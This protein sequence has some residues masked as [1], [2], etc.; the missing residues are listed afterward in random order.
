MIRAGYG[1]GEI[2]TLFRKRAQRQNDSGALAE[3]YWLSYADTVEM[4]EREAIFF[5]ETIEEFKLRFPLTVAVTLDTVRYAMSRGVSLDAE[6]A[7]ILAEAFCKKMH[8]EGYDTVYVI[9]LEQYEK[10]IF[11]E[12]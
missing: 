3:V 2:D 11:K 5:I 8:S 10:D 9:A 1:A 12:S 6:R 4:A 7:R